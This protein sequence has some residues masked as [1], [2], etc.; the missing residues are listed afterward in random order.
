MVA[1]RMARHDSEM[2]AGE[3]FA[4]GRYMHEWLG[5]LGH[6]GDPAPIGRALATGQVLQMQQLQNDC[7]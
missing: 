5:A 2:A 3:G 1:A 6:S 4:D 7:C